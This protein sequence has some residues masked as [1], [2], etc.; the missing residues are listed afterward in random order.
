MVEDESE[1]DDQAEDGHSFCSDLEWKDLDR[2]RD[3]E[4]SEGDAKNHSISLDCDRNEK[5]GQSL[6][7]RVEELITMVDLV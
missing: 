6:I 3:N 1:G 4:R 7:E 2:I 5:Y